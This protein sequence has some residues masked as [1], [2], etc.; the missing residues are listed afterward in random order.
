MD[1]GEYP[2]QSFLRVGEFFGRDDMVLSAEFFGVKG[3][4]EVFDANT[5]EYVPG[6]GVFFVSGGGVYRVPAGSFVGG[7]A[8][9]FTSS[10]TRP[11]RRKWAVCNEIGAFHLG[12][13]CLYSVTA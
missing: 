10:L 7:G 4:W 1:F 3:P 2:E 5:V 9:A 13:F 12:L 8:E 6:V 11:G